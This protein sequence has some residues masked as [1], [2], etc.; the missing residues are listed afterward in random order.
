MA[1]DVEKLKD[2]EM[3]FGGMFRGA[4]VKH[5][6]F[7]KLRTGG[8]RGCDRMVYQGYAPL[9]A[10]VLQFAAPPE[11][12]KPTIVEMGIFTGTGLAMWSVLYPE[13]DIIGLDV[14]V[15]RY[16]EH[17]ATLLSQ[18]AFG[19]GLPKVIEFDE[20]CDESWNALALQLPEGSVDVWI[21]DAIHRTDVILQAWQR[22][23]KFMAPR[24][25]YIIEDN[26]SIPNTM[27]K[28]YEGVAGYEVLTEGRLTAICKNQ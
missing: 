23:E 6:P 14:D 21:D 24:S 27:K 8:D 20:L 5:S 7:D 13:A 25:V 26:D 17:K 1:I 2:A 9:Y 12:H 28:R 3:K 19:A 15:D 4:R 10:R 22:A 11:M 16:E 18:G